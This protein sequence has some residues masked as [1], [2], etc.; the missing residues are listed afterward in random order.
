VVV[1]RNGVIVEQ[2]LAKEIFS[3][4]RE[5]YTKS[6]MRAAFDLDE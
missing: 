5:D 6:L 4:P 2:G 1:L 3:A